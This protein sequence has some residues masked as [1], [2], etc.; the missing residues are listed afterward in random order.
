MDVRCY[1]CGTIVD[2]GD[3]CPYCGTDVHV[4]KS[5]L[6]NSEILYNKGLGQAEVRDLSG[7]IVTLKESLRY[8]KRNTKARNLLGL[9]YFEIGEPVMAMSEWVLSKNLEN[10]NPLA[11]KYLNELQSEPGA[12]DNINQTIKKYNQA[13]EYCQQGSRDLAS[14]QLRKVLNLNPNFVAGHQLLALLYMQDGKYNDAKKELSAA[15]KVDVRNTITLRYAKECKEQLKELNK[16]K[17]KRRRENSISFQDG[18]DT[19]L[20][21]QNSFLDMVE[22]SKA[23]MGNVF[24]GL[25]IGLLICFFLVVPTVKQRAVEKASESLVATNE[26]LSSSSTNAM[27]LQQQVDDLKAQLEEYNGK[28]DTVQS[29][30]KL[31]EAQEALAAGN[32]QGAQEAVKIVNKDLLSDKGKA[33]YDQVY[34]GAFEQTLKDLYNS[35]YSAYN[36]GD[37]DAAIFNL[38]MC[39]DIDERYENGYA[40]FYLGDARYQKW[41][42]DEAISAFNKVIELVPDSP[43]AKKAQEKIDEYNNLQKSGFKLDGDNAGQNDGNNDNTSAN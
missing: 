17:K 10:D 7:A 9:I 3:I 35:G 24:V 31:I 16:N 20:M 27:T 14:I 32:V 8:N 1:N 15:N 39:V 26:E 43:A 19:I 21:P 37:L 6:Y 29:Y 28:G 4:Y 25:V 36:N 18:N 33:I 41:E 2:E 40:L 5:I 42:F 38:A 30:E 23:A 11:D 13:L 22:G 34:A 12:L